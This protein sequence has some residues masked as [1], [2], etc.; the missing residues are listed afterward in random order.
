[1]SQQQ[2]APKHAGEPAPP[3]VLPAEGSQEAQLPPAP[4]AAKATTPAPAPAAAAEE[5]AQ[6]PAEAP[7]QPET[8][9]PAP[10]AEEAA[11]EA[12]P[13]ADSE[14]LAWVD[15]KFAQTRAEW[16][17]RIGDGNRTQTGEAGRRIQAEAE[18]RETAIREYV[19]GLQAARLRQI[20]E[21]AIQ[22][23]AMTRMTRAETLAATRPDLTPA[24][25]AA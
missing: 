17:L 10:A 6:A 14:F 2:P 20:Q 8:P 13:A 4:P 19:S 21:A 5:P 1:M 7:A 9:E 3:A 16:D 24:R 23:Q 25:G 18:A 12:P 15:A 22:A 11:E